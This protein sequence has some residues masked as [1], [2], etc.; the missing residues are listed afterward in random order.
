MLRAHRADKMDR[1]SGVKAVAIEAATFRKR[2]AEDLPLSRRVRGDPGVVRMKANGHKLRR[3]HVL[4]AE[5][6]ELVTRLLEHHGF[7]VTSVRVD[8]WCNGHRPDLVARRGREVF[9]IVLQDRSARAGSLN[10]DFGLLAKAG[11][12]QGA[13]RSAGAPGRNGAAGGPSG[14][15]SMSRTGGEIFHLSWVL[16]DGDEAANHV[17]RARAALY[18]TVPI[19]DLGL[20]QGHESPLAWAGTYP[21]ACPCYYFTEGAFSRYGDALDAV[22]LSRPGRLVLCVNSLSSNV[23]RFRASS[24]AHAFSGSVVDPNR[25]ESSRIAFVLD[26]SIDRTDRAACL[27]H[28][29]HKYHTGPLVPLPGSVEPSGTSLRARLRRS[30]PILM[31]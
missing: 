10:G 25:M 12:I 23:R 29:R 5:R 15:A 26:E 16:F 27:E 1:H 6:K 3:V 20:E 18:G 14:R 19:T 8:E 4:D 28:L 9:I 24:M 22:V 21:K 11:G 2:A 30:R 7:S 13:S 31:D 17:D